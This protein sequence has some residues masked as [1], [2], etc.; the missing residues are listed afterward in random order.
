MPPMSQA[1]GLKNYSLRISVRVH[2]NAEDSNIEFAHLRRSGCARTHV[3]SSISSIF[4]GSLSSVISADKCTFQSANG[5]KSACLLQNQFRGGTRG[6][7]G[8]SLKEPSQA[9]DC[10]RAGFRPLPR[11]VW[12]WP[13]AA[14]YRLYRRAIYAATLRS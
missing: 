1:Q 11:S 5:V 6:T 2:I 10:F 9:P 14:R 4:F 13:D 12:I 3:C 8:R 7:G